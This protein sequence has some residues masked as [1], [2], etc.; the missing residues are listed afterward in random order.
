MTK[1]RSVA[2]ENGDISMILYKRYLKRRDKV[3]VVYS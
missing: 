3:S 2:V 1:L